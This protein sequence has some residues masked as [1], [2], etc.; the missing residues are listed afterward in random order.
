MAVDKKKLK[1]AVT[2]WGKEN[3][4]AEAEMLMVEM[5]AAASKRT[6]TYLQTKKKGA[7]DE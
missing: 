6:T 2:A 4:K 5:E 3:G 1:A 7:E